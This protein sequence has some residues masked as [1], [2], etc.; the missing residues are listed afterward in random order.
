MGKLIIGAMVSLDGVRRASVKAKPRVLFISY[1]RSFLWQRLE[2]RKVELV[3]LDQ[4]A[5]PQHSTES[6][7]SICA[8]Q[9]VS[10]K[11]LGQAC[12]TS[13]TPV[14]ISRA[15][16]SRGREKCRSIQIMDTTEVMTILTSRNDIT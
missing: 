12:P 14:K 11:E 6:F 9:S 4:G 8:R 2:T 16:S 1:A 13:T 10:L 3:V 15:P 7:N 5:D